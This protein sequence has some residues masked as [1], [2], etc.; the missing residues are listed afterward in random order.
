MEEH[1]L[2]LSEF[3]VQDCSLEPLGLQ[4]VIGSI[5]T[6]RLGHSPSSARTCDRP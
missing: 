4:Y 3:F 6:S 2:K 1:K 5:F